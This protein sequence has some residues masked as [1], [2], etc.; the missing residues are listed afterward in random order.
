MKTIEYWI[1]SSYKHEDTEKEHKEYLV[2]VVDMGDEGT[3]SVASFDVNQKEDLK[4]L[5]KHFNK[6]K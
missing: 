1:E 4:E 3:M 5:I 6:N 2:V